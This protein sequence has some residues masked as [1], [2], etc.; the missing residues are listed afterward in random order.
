MKLALVEDWHRAP[1]AGSLEGLVGL[2]DPGVAI[3]GPRGTARGHDVLRAWARGAGVVL[4]PVRWFCGARGDVLVGQRATWPDG[5][6]RRTAP[7]EVA[8]RFTVARGCIGRI[9]RHP[10][11]AAALAASGLSEADEVVE[12][13]GR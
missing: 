8:T 11:L 4:E 6:G 2:T 12:S 1:A 9:D 10:D 7:V 3:G 5:A 13:P